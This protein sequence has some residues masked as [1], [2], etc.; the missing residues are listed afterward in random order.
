MKKAWGSHLL[1]GIGNQWY[2]TQVYFPLNIAPY[3]RWENENLVEKKSS[4][5]LTKIANIGDRSARALHT[6]PFF[7]RTTDRLLC[8]DCCFATTQD[9]F[10]YLTSGG[11]GQFS[12]KGERLWHLE[13]CYAIAHKGT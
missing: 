10:L 11:L 4:F 6:D 13:V 3:N 9:I 8:R 12:H 7:S 5:C 1:R 2:L